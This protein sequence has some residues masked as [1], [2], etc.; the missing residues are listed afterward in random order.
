[1]IMPKGTATLCDIEK[2][3]NAYKR[4]GNNQVAPLKCT[5]A[6]PSPLE[7]VNLKT[8]PNLT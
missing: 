1:M 5:S 3:V 2:A 8:I 7:E 6:Y 4:I